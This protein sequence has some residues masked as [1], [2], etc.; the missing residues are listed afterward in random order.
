M[1]S[2]LSGG[3]PQPQPQAI[4]LG[5]CESCEQPAAARS[6]RTAFHSS[7]L[8]TA[9]SYVFLPSVAQFQELVHRRDYGC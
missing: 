4:R 8:T 3:A 1:Q 5:F 6:L 9:W 7:M 2:N